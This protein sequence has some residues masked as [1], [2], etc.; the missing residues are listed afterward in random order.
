MLQYLVS[1][2][3]LRKNYEIPGQKCRPAKREGLSFPACLR[4]LIQ[5][6]LPGKN[7]GNNLV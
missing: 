4:L 7:S 5:R 3:K 6:G 2:D 1:I